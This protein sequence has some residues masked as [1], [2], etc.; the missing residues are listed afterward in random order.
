M[1][2]PPDRGTLHGTGEE[3]ED[4]TDGTYVTMDIQ[5]IPMRERPLLLLRSRHTNPK[6]IRGGSIEGIND[7][8]VVLIAILI[9]RKQG[10]NTSPTTFCPSESP[11]TPGGPSPQNLAQGFDAPPTL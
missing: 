7:S 5:L 10:T 8:L 11:P 3:V 2:L 9:L 1:V 4:S 6:Q